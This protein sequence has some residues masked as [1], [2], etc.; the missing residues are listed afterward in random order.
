MGLTKKEQM[1]MRKLEQKAK[2]NMAWDTVIDLLASPDKERYVDLL[3]K[4]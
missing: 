4:V 1:E 2:V 3:E